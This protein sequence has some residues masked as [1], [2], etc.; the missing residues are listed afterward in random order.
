MSLT[1]TKPGVQRLAKCL[2]YGPTGHGKTYFLG[3][4]Q[5]DPRTY[6]MLLLAFEAGTSTLSG[7]DIDI[8]P[9]KSWDD[10]NEALRLLRS[11]KH[12]YKSV[13]V[14]S[15]SETHIFSLLTVAQQRAGATGSVL[16]GEITTDLNVR[17]D[18]DLL[19]Q[20]DYGK[21]RIQMLRFLRAFRDLPIHVFFT[22]TSM[23]ETDVREG[24]IKK[25]AMSGSLRD[26]LPAIVDV[27]AYLAVETAPDQSVVARHLILQN[28]PKIRAKVRTPWGVTCPD[29]IADPT[30]TKL[31][32][33]LCIPV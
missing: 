10:Y 1:I 4:A 20:Q 7:L 8:A 30:V 32:D 12:E 19:Q 22:A 24:T 26:E 21:S 6:P 15:V 14:D 33:A 3:T 29:E 28:Y 23:E 31:L 5:D 25:P 9:I 13:G 18:P 11:G 17:D 27:S 2:V 16:Q